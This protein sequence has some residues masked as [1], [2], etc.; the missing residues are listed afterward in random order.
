MEKTA[1]KLKV[2]DRETLKYI[3]V[4]PMALGHFFGSYYGSQTDPDNSVLLFLLT[5]IALVAPPIFFLF[6]CGG[7]QI[8]SFA[9]KIR[10]APARFRDNNSDT[11]LPFGKRHAADRGYFLLP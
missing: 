4:I 10:A 6:H 8:Y 11:V 1:E 2:I 9:Q 7:L 3:A 5:H